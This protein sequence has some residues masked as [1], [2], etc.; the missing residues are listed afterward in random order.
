MGERLDERRVLKQ[1]QASAVLIA[2]LDAC[3]VA[4]QGNPVGKA[5]VSV[6]WQSDCHVGQRETQ[7]AAERI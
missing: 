7:L 6:R 4:R 2:E 1:H 5:R 3:V